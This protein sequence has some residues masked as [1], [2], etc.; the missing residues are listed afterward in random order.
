MCIRS[1]AER[2][3]QEPPEEE[4]VASKSTGPAHHQLTMTLDFS[5]CDSVPAVSNDGC[6]VL[7]SLTDSLRVLC[8]K[9]PLQEMQWD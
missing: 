5:V 4:T 2:E 8:I 3:D 7:I 6:K 1:Q 9:I